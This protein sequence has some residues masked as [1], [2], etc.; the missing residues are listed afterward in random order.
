[1][2]RYNS[3]GR[4][5]GHGSAVGKGVETVA[6]WSTGHTNWSAGSGSMGSRTSVPAS[7]Q[8]QPTGGHGGPSVAAAK[9]T[10]CLISHTLD[11]G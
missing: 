3:A 10:E 4:R 9:A 2:G 11:G 1:M 7:Q 6:R 5:G 8:S